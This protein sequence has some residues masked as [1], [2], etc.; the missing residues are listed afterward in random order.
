MANIISLNGAVQARPSSF[1]LGDRRDE[2]PVCP[3]VNCINA[4]QI[5]LDILKHLELR[6]LIAI[7]R[8]QRARQPPDQICETVYSCGLRHP[9]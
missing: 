3:Q 5:D 6:R 9:G 4:F 1:W 7:G 8:R 2:L